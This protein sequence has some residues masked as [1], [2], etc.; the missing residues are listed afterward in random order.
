[1]TKQRTAPYALEPGG[2]TGLAL[3]IKDNVGTPVHNG[4]ATKQYPLHDSKPTGMLFSTAYRAINTQVP[5]TSA[6]RL[7]LYG[8]W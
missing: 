8:H 1:M 3:I 6:P 5:W 7:L 2:A 4:I